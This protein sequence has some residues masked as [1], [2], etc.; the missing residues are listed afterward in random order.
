MSFNIDNCRWVCYG[1]KT[2]YDTFGHI[3]AAFERALK[4]LGKDVRWLDESDIGNEP[5]DNTCFLTMNTVCKGIPKRLDCFYVVHNASELSGFFDGLKIMGWGVHISTNSYE[6]RVEQIGPDIY[7]DKES[8]VIQFRWATD[9]LPHEIEN[10]KPYFAINRDSR[11]INYVGT[12]DPS[13]RQQFAKF[14]Y[15]ALENG[16]EMRQ[17]GGYSGQPAVSIED[18]VRLI[19]GSYMAPVIQRQSQVDT[20]YIPCRIFKNISY[21]HFGVT[22]SKYVNDLF[23]NKLIYNEDPYKLFYQAK[24]RLLAMPP[25]PKELYDL[26]DLVAKDFTYLNLVNGVTEAVRRLTC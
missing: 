9:L 4:Y 6:K 8:R 1:A 17:Y 18:N 22:H 23:K 14:G 26:M 16:I 15:A 7:F 11:V 12:I 3:F 24:E 20:G 10:N 19:K 21:G 2:K 5:F 13:N 25:E